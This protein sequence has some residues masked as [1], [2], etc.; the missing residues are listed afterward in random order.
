M[1]ESTQ[2]ADASKQ[3][4]VFLVGAGPGDPGLI[5][6]R[7]VACLRQADVAVYDYLVPKE[8]MDYLPP[9]AE[10]LFVGKLAGNHFVEQEDINQLLIDKAQEGKRVV[11]LKGGDPFIFGRGG[12]ECLALVGA[13]VP[14][15]VVPGICAAVGVSAYAGIPVTQRGYASSL[16]LVTA[17][18]SSKGAELNINWEQLARAGDTL[19][20]YMGMRILPEIAE[21]LQQHGCAPDTPVAVVQWG[22]HPEQRTVTGTLRDIAEKV[23]K[24]GLSRPGLIIVGEVVRLREQLNWFERDAHPGEDEHPA[25]GDTTACP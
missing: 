4:K 8:L 11:R 15:E 21:Q 3:G 2:G 7:G 16:Y 20:I 18:L 25:Q 5:T 10:R 6:V 14:F 23:S 13:G 17:H 9:H 1:G 22:T 19:C 24:A 12:E